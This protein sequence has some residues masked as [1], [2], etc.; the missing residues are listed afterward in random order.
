MI[1]YKSLY[2]NIMWNYKKLLRMSGESIRIIL[3]RIVHFFFNTYH[4]YEC[5]PFNATNV[6][7]HL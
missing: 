1:Q 5:S 2:K 3:Q 4:D 7:K 6:S